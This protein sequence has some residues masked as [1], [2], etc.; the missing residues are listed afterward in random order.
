MGIMSVV[1][2]ILGLFLA[3]LVEKKWPAQH[4]RP[5][6]WLTRESLLVGV[7]ILLW[8]V[9]FQGIQLIVLNTFGRP[10]ELTTKG[11]ILDFILV[12]VG[13]DFVLYWMHRAYHSLELLWRVHRW[14]HSVS[15]LNAFTGF[16]ASLLE[17]LITGFLTVLLS[18][19][20]PE[21]IPWFMLYYIGTQIF[22]H[23]EVEYLSFGGLSKFIITP[24]FHRTHHS[25]APE[26]YNKNF[27]NLWLIWDQV[28]GTATFLQVPVTR[29]GLNKDE[30]SQIRMSIGI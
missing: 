10:I 28:F 4:W 2:F 9:I 19:W 3:F 26:H 24:E 12:F 14:H 13:W 29:V 22:M 16:R 1:V 21:S 15:Q 5:T 7:V 18:V 25:V 6:K 8:T 23:L 11:I 27:G 30:A 17:I 20:R